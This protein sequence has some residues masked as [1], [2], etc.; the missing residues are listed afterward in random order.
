MNTRSKIVAG[1][2][3]AVLFGL[4]LVQSGCPRSDIAEVADGPS[5]DKLLVFYSPRSVK[6]RPFTKPASFDDDAIPDGI[7]VFLQPA[8]D[9]GDPVKAIGT[10]IFELYSHR[11]AAGDDRGERLQ[12]WRQPVLDA[13]QRR[14]FWNH[15]I[16]MYQFQLSWEGKPIP[17]QQ[18]YVLTVSFQAPGSER[19]FDEYEFEFRIP[20]GE[21]LSASSER[22]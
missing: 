18:K 8:D 22:E 4:L 21:V 1:G 15:V 17:P 19:L 14:Q 2:P 5:K 3:V 7:D 16:S 6:I 20:R 12:T 13:E 9:D 11:S 10:F